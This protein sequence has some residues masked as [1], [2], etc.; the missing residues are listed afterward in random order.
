VRDFWNTKEYEM[1]FYDLC[2]LPLS[3]LFNV[4][5]YLFFLQSSVACSHFSAEAM[6]NVDQVLKNQLVASLCG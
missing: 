6:L 5:I 1:K 4:L 2:I 3:A